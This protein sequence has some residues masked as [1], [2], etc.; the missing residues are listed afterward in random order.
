MKIMNKVAALITCVLGAFA[1]NVQACPA[2]FGPQDTYTGGLKAG[3][4]LRNNQFTAVRIST[5]AGLFTDTCTDRQTAGA[6]MAIGVIQNRPN[7][8]E[9]ATVAYGGLTKM[10]GGGTVTAG[11][12]VTC[13]TSG[14]AINASSGDVA[15]GR[16]MET[17]ATA[18]HLGS[19][20]LFPPVRTSSVA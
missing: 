17:L 5:G 7:S 14:R 13:D 9:A 12:L 20:H 18:G 10:V 1:L 15:I 8:G 6:G 19:V 4:D 2:D 16:A 3:A 11:L